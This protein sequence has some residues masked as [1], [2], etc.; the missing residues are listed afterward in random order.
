MQSAV[1]LRRKIRVP[2]KNSEGGFVLIAA[3]MGIMILLAVGFL[4]L[5]ISSSD[6]RIASRLIG[7]RKAFSA[8]ESG[9]QDFMASFSPGDLEKNWTYVDSVNDPGVQFRINEPTRDATVPDLPAAGFDT[10]MSYA[11]YGT[12]V[13][14]RDNTYK[15]QAEIGVGAKYGPISGGFGYE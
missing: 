11:V 4:A 12:T 10:E 13:I 15:S 9:V 1:S 5:T 8:A 3:I 6:I 14:G 7:E 2:G